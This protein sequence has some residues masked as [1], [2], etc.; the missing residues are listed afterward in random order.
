[1][2][3]FTHDG[4]TLRYLVD[5]PMDGPPVLLVHGFASNI[6]MNW[7]GPGWVRALAEAGY[8]V[9]AIDNRGHGRSDKPH[10][11]AAYIPERMARDAIALLDHLHIERAVWI[12][13]SMGGRISAFA[14][15]AEPSRLSALVL[16]GIGMGL[17]LGLDDADGIA[18]ALLASSLDQVEGARPR[19][20]RAFA[21]KTKSDRLALAA[22]IATSRKSLTPSQ[23][24]TIDVP[25]LVA[26]GTR[27][28][29]AGSAE[30]LAALMPRATALAIPD[31]DHMLS[32]GDRRFIDGTIAFLKANVSEDRP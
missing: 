12:G 20:F 11:P 2:P 6:E 31:R 18:G 30:E 3:T 5:G 17:V 8:R 28:D 1:M 4:L 27:D 10:D 26:V 9:I 25:C 29:I 24:A 7:V 15:L 19:M 21:D 32:V 22:C 16:G 13:Y 14:A 23:V